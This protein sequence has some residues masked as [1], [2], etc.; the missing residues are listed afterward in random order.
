MAVDADGSFGAA[1]GLSWS[2]LFKVTR[3]A[4]SVRSGSAVT[5]VLSSA[6]SECATIDRCGRTP[7]TGRRSPGESSCLTICLKPEHLIIILVIALLIFGPSKLPG[8]GKGLGEAFRGFKEGIKGNPD[9]PDARQA[10]GKRRRKVRKRDAAG[11]VRLPQTQEPR[12]L[13]PHLQKVRLLCVGLYFCALL[14]YGCVPPRR[15]RRRHRAEAGRYNW[16]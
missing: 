9:N 5:C 6:D 8:L 15:R 3:G 14:T 11:E 13:K 12:R 2:I 10:A 16:L 7:V 1:H 4:G